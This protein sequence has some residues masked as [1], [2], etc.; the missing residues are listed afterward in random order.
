M[1]YIVVVFCD[2]DPNM[3]AFV[4]LS[5]SPPRGQ[6]PADD[7]VAV[8]GTPSQAQGRKK[9]SKNSYCFMTP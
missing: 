2:D 9:L 8:G 3:F 7:N 4:G 6:V 5:P 1:Y